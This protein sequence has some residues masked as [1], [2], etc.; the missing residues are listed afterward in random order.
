[1]KLTKNKL[2]ASGKLMLFGEY[3]VLR[4][5][6][7]L[8]FPLTFGQ[9]LEVQPHPTTNWKSY[10]RNHCWFEASFDENLDLVSTNDPAAGKILSNLFKFI[11]SKKPEVNFSYS[12]KTTAD[13]D[14]NWGLGSSSTLI[15]LLSQWSGC[16]AYEMLA[17][18]F[19][20]S[21]YD[22]AC[23][24]AKSPII[25]SK[26]SHQIEEVQ[27]NPAITNQMLFVYLGKK[28]NSRDEIKRFK[29]S[30][31]TEKHIQ[32]INKIIRQ[33]VDCE[34]ID[35]F[36]QLIENAE[37][38]ISPIIGKER[39]KQHIFADY[40]HSIKSLGAWGGDFFLATYRDLNAAKEYFTSKG[41][42][43]MFTYNELILK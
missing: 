11:R 42:T 7:S 13:F 4:G 33:T 39:L 40:T 9:D 8:A 16:N 24:N 32:S 2:R 3:T 37:R 29:T 20:G 26:E 23:A 6:E 19:G 31:V 14:L 36:E 22:V 21:G 38:L 17:A 34:D 10:D 15:S 18:S 41:F 1:M 35:N 43:T 27:L 28:Q 25:F 5:S 30:E 12:F